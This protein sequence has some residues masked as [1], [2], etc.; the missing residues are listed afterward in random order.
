VKAAEAMAMGFVSELVQPEK[1]DDAIA[2]L[3]ERLCVAAPQSVA[4]GRTAFYA[5]VNHDLD[6]RI[7]MLQAHLSVSLTMPDAREGLAAFAEKRK[8]QWGDGS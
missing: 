2:A 4:L 8:P 7:R 3:A 5:A 6:S 1:L